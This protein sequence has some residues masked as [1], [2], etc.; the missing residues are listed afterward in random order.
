MFVFGGQRLVT[1]QRAQSRVQRMV[2]RLWFAFDMMRCSQHGV[3][4]CNMDEL[5]SC[6]NFR[7]GFPEDGDEWVV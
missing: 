3:A 7:Q 1:G 2:R 4:A 5:G 6:W